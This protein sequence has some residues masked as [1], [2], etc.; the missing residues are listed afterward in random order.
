MCHNQP[1]D[2]LDVGS[3]LL[4]YWPIR[5]PSFAGRAQLVQSVL[6]RAVHWYGTSLD[7]I[8]NFRL[9]GK[10]VRS[11]PYNPATLPSDRVTG[12]GGGA[13]LIDWSGLRGL[14]VSAPLPYSI[15]SCS[16]AEAI[17]QKKVKR[18]L[19]CQGI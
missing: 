1:E 19:K 13:G 14:I 4:V 10:S 7:S 15:D 9:S 12:T 16:F 3:S 18:D 11:A 8:E 2:R 6:S 17:L 5:C